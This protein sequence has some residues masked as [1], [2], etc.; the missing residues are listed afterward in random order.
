MQREEKKDGENA[1]FKAI[2][3][4]FLL[5]SKSCSWPFFYHMLYYYLILLKVDQMYSLLSK[6]PWKWSLVN[7]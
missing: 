3:K 1:F 6:S 5:T 4:H 2:A 7:K